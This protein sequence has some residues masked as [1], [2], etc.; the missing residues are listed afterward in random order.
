MKFL[1]I[2]KSQSGGLYVVV[3]MRELVGI[4]PLVLVHECNGVPDEMVHTVVAGTRAYL[5]F[6]E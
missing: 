5:G 1:S 6:S 3:V 2:E 4:V